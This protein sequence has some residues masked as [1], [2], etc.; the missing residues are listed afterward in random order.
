MTQMDAFDRKILAALQSDGRLTNAELAEAVGLSPSQCSRRRSQLETS[1]IIEGYT[2]R[3]NPAKVGIGLTSIISVTL[4]SHD[5]QNA[6][7]L[8]AL[9]SD[10]PN[11][12]D[13]Y[14][15]TGEMD[16]SIKVVCADLEALSTFINKTL[17]PH[18]A[19]QNVRTAIVL[20]TLKSSSSLPLSQLAP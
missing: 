19:V 4:A 1:G 7:R 20:D 6:A 18:E 11:V 16:Y 8:R 17:L 9:L 12:Q 5:E 15:L 14:A 10:L 13:A 3:I 2:A